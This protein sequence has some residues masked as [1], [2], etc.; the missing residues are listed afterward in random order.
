MPDATASRLLTAEAR[1]LAALRQVVA[2]HAGKPRAAAPM[3]VAAVSQSRA[4]ARREGAAAMAIEVRRTLPALPDVRDL[5]DAYARRAVAGYLKAL[6][7]AEAKREAGESV[8]V[9]GIISGK[10]DLIAATEVPSAFSEE[11]ER[12]EVR[13]VRDEPSLIPILLKTWNAQLD[14]ACPVCRGLHRQAR[15]WGVDFERGQKPGR[16]HIR[17]RC[18]SSYLPIPVVTVGALRRQERRSWQPWEQVE[19]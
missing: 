4:M 10:L 17:C 8:H 19:D 2:L 9:A 15:P 1:C 13:F 6:D 16:V 5:D 12:I 7:G 3:L 11:R 14:R 18:W